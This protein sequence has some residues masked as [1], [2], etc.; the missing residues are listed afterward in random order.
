MCGGTP[1]IITMDGAALRAPGN[2]Q[3]PD[4]NGTPDVLGGVGPGLTWF[5]TSVFST[6]PPNTFGNAPR[7]GVLDG[8]AYN[9][10][11]ATLAKI[12]VLPHGI[13]GEFRIDTFNV[14]NSPPLGAPNGSFGSAAFGSI[15][16]AGDPRVIQLG[17]KFL[18]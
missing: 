2:T 10:L 6:P 17:L 12:F 3:R 15:N 8:P 7:N 18:F 11:D 16:S 5:D 13:R 4:V 14:T 1:I 9:N